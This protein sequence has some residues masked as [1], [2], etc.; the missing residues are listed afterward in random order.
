MSRKT[1]AEASSTPSL[2]EKELSLLQNLLLTSWYFSMAAP[3]AGRPLGVTEQSG[4][5][6]GT[7]CSRPCLPSSRY[8][9]LPLPLRPISTQGHSKWDK[10]N[11]VRRETLPHLRFNSRDFLNSVYY[12]WECCVCPPYLGFFYVGFVL[13]G[14]TPQEADDGLCHSSFDLKWTAIDP[15]PLHDDPC[16]FNVCVLR[17]LSFISFSQSFVLFYETRSYSSAGCPCNLL[18]QPG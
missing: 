3:L 10:G 8:P 17:A 12:L 5:T 6:P 15:L 18:W 16:C 11:T 14:N 4:K 2:E 13:L 9:L 7:H 1:G